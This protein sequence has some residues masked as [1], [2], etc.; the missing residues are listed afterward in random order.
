MGGDTG[1]NDAFAAGH[2]LA[3]VLSA[4]VGSLVNHQLPSQL[5]PS[6]S[7]LTDHALV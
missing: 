1:D 2:Q 4:A 3:P 5:Q 6:Y 7:M